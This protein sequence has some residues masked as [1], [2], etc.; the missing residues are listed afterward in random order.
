MTFQNPT[1]CAPDG[2]K[3]CF[4]CC[5]P[6]RPHGYEHIQYETIIKRVLREN[7]F[8]FGKRDT[9]VSPITGFS[10]W[11]LGYLD[12]KYRRVGCLLHPLQN[13][14]EDL[15][16]RVDYGEKCR[17]ESC[18]EAKSFSKLSE[19]CGKFWLH[20]A[21][22]L[23]SFSYSSKIR[24]PLFAILGWGTHLLEL[25]SLV[26]G[27]ERRERNAFLL[28]YP[29]FEYPGSPKAHAYLLKHLIGEG[30]VHLLKREAFKGELQRF[31]GL[32]SSDL[33]RS[34]EDVPQAVHVHRLPMDR[35]FLDFLRLSAGITR[36]SHEGAIRLKMLTDERL[37]QFRALLC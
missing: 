27:Y 3:T 33:R 2:L 13:Q 36:V 24:N 20:L 9:A 32:L 7:T 14:G 15:R 8:S 5:P 1:L 6:I 18:P 10:C 30:N 37:R 25:V 22:D 16:F 34:S 31:C 17:R 19:K 26:E 4:A 29:F 11:A 35:D 23:D 28:E 12:G 21:D